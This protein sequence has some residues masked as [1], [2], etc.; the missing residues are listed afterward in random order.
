MSSVKESDI[1]VLVPNI[2][3]VKKNNKSVISILNVNVNTSWDMPEL[4]RSLDKKTYIDYVSRLDP[5]YA[6]IIKQLL[7]TTLYVNFKDFKSNLI[8]SFMLFANAIGSKPVYLFWE[9]AKFGSGNWLIQLLWP[10]IRQLNINIKGIITQNDDKIPETKLDILIIDDA[11]YSGNHI[12]SLID[13]WSYNI[14]NKQKKNRRVKQKEYLRD[15]TIKVHIVVSYINAVGIQSITNNMQ[16]ISDTL[17]ITIYSSVEFK[18]Y[19]LPMDIADIFDV[20][21]PGIVSNI[22]FDHKV[23]NN[24]GSFPQIYLEGFIPNS[25]TKFGPL[26]KNLPSRTMIEKL[27]LTFK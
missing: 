5:K 2:G 21:F 26:M 15:Y 19:I 3:K 22:Y 20:Q 14:T 24:F 7:D 13:E 4:D 23:A 18:P 27:E 12:S 10:L 6:N 16:D 17:D 25:K 9:T 1:K 8:K 11:I